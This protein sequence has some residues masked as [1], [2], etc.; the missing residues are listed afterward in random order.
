VK[1]PFVPPSLSSLAEV[2][3]SNVVYRQETVTVEGVVSPSGQGGCGG[4]HSD[5]WIHSFELAAWRFPGRDVTETELWILRAVPPDA[6][7]AKEFRE[8]PECAIVRLEVLL[9]EDQESAVFYRALD[10]NV[11]ED[12]LLQV[13]ERLKQPLTI[14]TEA[15]GE[16]VLDRRIGWFDGSAEWNGEQVELSLRP[17]SDNNLDPALRAA[18]AIWTSQPDLNRQIEA[19]LVSE[20]LE[21]KND[22][23]L[24][25]NEAPLCAVELLERLELISISVCGDGHFE[26]YYADDDM[27]AGHRVNVR[28]SLTEGPTE[29]GLAG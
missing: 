4:H 11:D 15:F 19:S 10:R 12:E 22:T 28:G 16:F 18:E 3:I 29:V 21:L 26:F 14:S 9:A 27:F 23:W 17:D 24:L 2:G 20:L 5:H 1:E 6:D 25:E 7:M 8:F 13:A